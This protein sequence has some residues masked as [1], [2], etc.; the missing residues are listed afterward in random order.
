MRRVE[1]VIE[2]D[3]PLERVFDL[4]SDFESFPRWMRHVGEVRRTG[5]RYTRWRAPQGVDMEWEVETTRF[6]PDQ[7]I[8]WR[9]VGGDVETDAEVVF[10]EIDAGTTHMR[11]VIGY[12]PAA[13]QSGDAFARLFGRDPA[14]ELGA[15]LR[16]FKRLAEGTRSDAR[17]RH[18]DDERARREPPRERGTREREPRSDER[19]YRDVLGLRGR[20]ERARRERYDRD[21]R[22]PYDKDER[23]FYDRDERSV[24]ARDEGR[25]ASRYRAASEP[26]REERFD[27][28]LRAARR[29]QMESMR[30]Y[31][32]SGRPSPAW[33]RMLEAE[34]GTRQDDDG[35][36]R[37]DEREPDAE[38]MMERRRRAP[39]EGPP[40]PRRRMDEAGPARMDESERDY[41]PRYALTPRERERE[42]AERDWDREAKARVMRRGLDRLLEDGPSREWR[43]WDRD[44]DE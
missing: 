3:A 25:R 5:R 32:E 12:A 6:E 28:A 42:R 26:E 41:R 1:R 15:D 20:D 2:I 11:V 30:R 13:G 22:A 27:E 21:E 9:S 35:R 16:R 23:A 39:V 44:D 7:H 33:Q 37:R 29:S 18:A 19:Y 40:P 36:R 17:R 4:F 24:Y 38:R 8:A 10:S 31:H 14:A 34:R 43:R